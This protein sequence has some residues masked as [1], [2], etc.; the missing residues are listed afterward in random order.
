AGVGA[1]GTIP[2]GEYFPSA[3]RY[4]TETAFSDVWNGQPVAGQWILAITDWDTGYTGSLASWDLRFAVE[5][6][7][8]P[9]DPTEI[10]EPAT[11][12]MLA[13]GMIGLVLFGRKA[14]SRRG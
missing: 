6:G 2:G 11:T 13:S 9:P 10:P 7:S 8:L 14:A 12:A 4:P 5:G 1:T 3:G